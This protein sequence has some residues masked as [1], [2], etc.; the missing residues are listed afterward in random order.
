M[1]KYRPP[2]SEAKPHE[3]AGGLQEQNAKPSSVETAAYAFE[4][5]HD[6]ISNLRLLSFILQKEGKEGLFKHLSNEK[7]E[8]L[9]SYIERVKS[10]NQDLYTKITRDLISYPDA[11][12]TIEALISTVNEST[13][14]EAAVHAFQDLQ[15]IFK[16]KPKSSF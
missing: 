8:S 13:T 12:N 14:P 15:S 16:K 4:G 2:S 7:L 1:E 11:K 9:N 10:Q 3:P 5:M 6:Y